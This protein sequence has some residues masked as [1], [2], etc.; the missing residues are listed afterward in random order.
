MIFTSNNQALINDFWNR[1][2]LFKMDVI[3][4]LMFI[5]IIPAVFFL[6][7][8]ISLLFNESAKQFNLSTS[9]DV[10]KG[11]NFLGLFLSIF[12]A[13][14]L[15]ELGWRS[16]GVDSL[17]SHFNLFYTSLIFAFLWALWHL[18]LLFI[19]GYYLCELKHLSMI[20]VINFFVSLVPLSILLNWIFY[21]N[22]R[23]ILIIILFHAL[24]NAFSVL[25][26]I[27]QLAKCI[28]TILLLILSIVIIITDREAFFA[29]SSNQALKKEQASFFSNNVLPDNSAA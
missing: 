9:I 28:V 18:P 13:P 8:K 2:F 19:K 11:W 4:V 16:Y 14:T 27:K 7:V 29:T 22:F 1:L 6:S 15:E 12:L 23:S 10:I 17:L 26:K 3:T 20:Y 5:T 21:K 24:V 25:F